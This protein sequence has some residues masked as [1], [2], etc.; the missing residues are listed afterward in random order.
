MGTACIL[1]YANIFTAKFEEMQIY[2]FIKGKVELYLRYINDIL[3][4]RKDTE[5]WL[6]N[7]IN[8]INKKQPS[9]RFDQKYSEPE[10]KFL[11]VLVYK[12]EQQGL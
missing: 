7:V 11:G 6:K 10:I 12:D 4:I 1:S 9:I 8:E 2:L 5:K 3:F